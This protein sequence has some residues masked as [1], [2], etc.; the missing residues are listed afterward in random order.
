MCIVNRNTKDETDGR[1]S[2]RQNE[3]F[4]KIWLVNSLWTREN[5]VNIKADE[6]LSRKWISMST[7]VDWAAI[8]SDSVHST[9]VDWAAITSDSVQ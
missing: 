1:A 4:L 6:K 9:G 5:S 3:K 7:G 2:T 8:T